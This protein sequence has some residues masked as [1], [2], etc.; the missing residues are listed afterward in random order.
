MS[1]FVYGQAKL[2]HV[3]PDVELP[4]VLMLLGDLNYR[5]SGFKKSVV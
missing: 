3:L 1:R 5:I 4:D 2:S